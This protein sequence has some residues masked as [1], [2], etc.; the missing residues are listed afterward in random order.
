MRIGYHAPLPPARTGVADYAEALLQA[1]Q[2]HAAVE[3]HASQAD[4]HIYQLGNN[5]LHLPYYE[6]ALRTPGAVLLHDANLH[7]FYLGSSTAESYIH[8]FTT[9]YGDWY[10]SLA[11]TLWRNR[12]RSA[13]DER[14]FRYAMLRRVVTTATHILVHNDAARDIALAHG[15]ACPVH[16][17]PHLA[18]DPPMLHPGAAIDLRE[19]LG[20]TSNHFLYAIFGHLRETKRILSTLRAFHLAR[21]RNPA[22]RLLIAGS[23]VT[24]DLYKT[25]A[26]LLAH[27]AILTTGYLP[28]TAFWT[29][30]QAID[31]A[32]NLR[33]PSCGETSGIAIRMMSLAKPVLVT[34]GAE[35]A[36]YPTASYIPISPGP[37]EQSE[38]AEW[39]VQ[40]AAHR[41]W[42]RDI[43]QRAK[44]HIQTEHAPARAANLLLQALR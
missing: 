39:M 25:V 34:Q 12:A 14:Y 3:P 26:P 24:N 44:L 38:L 15:A 41:D 36:A 19:S 43:G 9:Q 21:Q 13:A 42:A 35:Y 10:R 40:L 29:Y 17:I 22:I 31:A 1:L 33:Y 32:I 30:A 7:H 5:Q 20:L 2:P 23:F 37:T 4:V 27:P 28:E 18:I 11:E 6:R 8:E 16:V